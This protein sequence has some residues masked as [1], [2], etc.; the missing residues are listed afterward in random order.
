MHSG[1]LYSEDI[2]ARFSPPPVE[3]AVDAA[4]EHLDDQCGR[5]VFAAV[6]HRVNHVAHAMRGG[7]PIVELL[8]GLTRLESAHVC[9]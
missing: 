6:W 5:K 3:T 8:K 2:P 1:S 4:E 7:Q 9:R